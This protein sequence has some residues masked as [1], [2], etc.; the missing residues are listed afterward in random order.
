M[1]KSKNNYKFNI[2]ETVKYINSDGT[3]LI[4]T[5]IDIHYDTLPDLYYTIKLNKDHIKQ[6]TSNRLMKYY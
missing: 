4:V 6:T 3:I 2:N 5:I 1:H